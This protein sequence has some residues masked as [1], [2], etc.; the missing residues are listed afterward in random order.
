MLLLSILLVFVLAAAVAVPTIAYYIRTGGKTEG[1][2]TPANP[3]EPSFTDPTPS[4][5]SFRLLAGDQNMKDVFIYVPDR[6]FPIFVRV[7]IVVSWKK[8]ADCTCTHEICNSPTCSEDCECPNSPNCPDDCEDCEDCLKVGCETCPDCEVGDCENCMG[9]CE[10]C[11][12]CGQV[13]CESCT[14]CPDDCEDCEDCE[15]G[16]TDCEGCK[17]L[18]NCG[19]CTDCRDC[20]NS[21]ID[22]ND[23]PRC[24]DDDS[25]DWDVIFAVPVKGEKSDDE[26][27]YKMERGANWDLIENDNASA[28]T[29]GF[30]CYYMKPVQS[31]GNVTDKTAYIKIPSPA[32]TTFEFLDNARPPVNDCILNVEIIVQTIQAIGYTDMDN[33][34]DGYVEPA[35]RDAWKNAP[36]FDVIEY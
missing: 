13:K 36:D 2:Y 29:N 1:D 24:N 18:S 4:N 22:R 23:C 27:D 5:P 11:E 21:C 15:G 34:G 3:N 25:D 10:D 9:N 35:W 26:A 16:C 32:I 17:Q 33:D 6:G 20:L 30:Y 12:V 28:N 8:L 14:G 31:S 7:E 19:K